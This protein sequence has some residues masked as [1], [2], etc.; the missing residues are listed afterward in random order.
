MT[1]QQMKNCA[2]EGKGSWQI[3]LQKIPVVLHSQW[4]IGQ[5]CQQKVKKKD[6]CSYQNTKASKMKAAGSSCSWRH[7]QKAANKTFR[8]SFDNQ[9]PN[10]HLIISSC[11][12]QVAIPY[13][14]LNSILQVENACPHIAGFFIDYLQNVGGGNERACFNTTEHLWAKWW[15]KDRR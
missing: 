11:E 6:T 15:L 3:K 9:V 5:P 14:E 12:Q 13:L 4:Q 10:W 7:H 8:E 2:T 1:E